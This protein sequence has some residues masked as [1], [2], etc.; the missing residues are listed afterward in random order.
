MTEQAVGFRLQI[1]PSADANKGPR[2]L[3]RD[4]PG[5]MIADM[6]EADHEMYL[7]F[8]PRCAGADPSR[9]IDGVINRIRNNPRMALQALPTVRRIDDTAMLWV[10]FKRSLVS[11]LAEMHE[12]RLAAH[13]ATACGDDTIAILRKLS[14]R[15]QRMHT[16]SGTWRDCRADLTAQLEQLAAGVA[17]EHAQMVR[18]RRELDENVQRMITAPGGARCVV[19]TGVLLKAAQALGNAQQE[20]RALM[21]EHIARD[22]RAHADVI[23]ATFG[24]LRNFAHGFQNELRELHGRSTAAQHALDRAIAVTS[25]TWRTVCQ[26]LSQQYAKTVHTP[27]LELADEIGFASVSSAAQMASEAL[28][29]DSDPHCVRRCEFALDELGRIR[30]ELLRRLRNDPGAALPVDV[31]ALD[32]DALARAKKTRAIEMAQATADHDRRMAELRTE[33]RMRADALAHA[34]TR[35]SNIEHR[36]KELEVRASEEFQAGGDAD[37]RRM[38]AVARLAAEHREALMVELRTTKAQISGL[39]RR[40]ADA[41]AQVSDR[42]RLLQ[43]NVILATVTATYELC[44]K[45]RAQFEDAVSAETMTQR[46]VNDQFHQTARTLHAH[47]RSVLSKTVST[48]RSHGARIDV[49]LGGIEDRVH[50]IT[51]RLETLN[52]ARIQQEMVVDGPEIVLHTVLEKYVIKMNQHSELMDAHARTT[53]MVGVC[54]AALMLLRE[55]NPS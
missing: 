15:S 16:T 52:T 26:D 10:A 27:L 14:D 53:A 37:G 31:D 42:D 46:L 45:M 49:E 35:L 28:D 12:L 17:R 41:R 5:P 33:Q 55:F 34:Q 38:A 39:E 23:R 30:N 54:D 13:L 51:R 4:D 8:Q 43:T 11:T 6:G 20:R 29:N 32:D 21:D 3:V 25:K 7:T 48:V 2:I 24:A 19:T 50:E 44:R 40:V 1:R 9:T 22:G 36:L 18:A 47:A